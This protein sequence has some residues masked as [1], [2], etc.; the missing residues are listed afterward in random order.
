MKSRIFLR[1]AV[2]RA[3]PAGSKEGIVPTLCGPT[4]VGP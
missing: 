1:S 4:E 2:L 3:G